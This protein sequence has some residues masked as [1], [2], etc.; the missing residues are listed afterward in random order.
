MTAPRILLTISRRWKRWS[1]VRRVLTEIHAKYPDAI[2]VHGDC[3]DGDRTAAGMW[4]SMGG[5]DEPWPAPW[6]SACTPDCYHRPRVRADGTE[7]CPAPGPARNKRMVES[8]PVM[9][10]AFLRNKSRGASGCAELS[11]DAGIPTVRYEYEE[12][13]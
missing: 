11:E 13:V 12:A 9:T 3:P 8:A 7:Y 10:V 4:R 2:L 1:E 5:K 6:G